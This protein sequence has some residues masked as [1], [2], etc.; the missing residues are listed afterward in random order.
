MIGESCQAS[1]DPDPVGVQNAAVPLEK[2]SV[3]SRFLVADA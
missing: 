1:P 2:Y 3:M